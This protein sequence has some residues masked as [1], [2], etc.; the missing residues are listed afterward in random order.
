MR[1]TLEMYTASRMRNMVQLRKKNACF[2]TSL[3]FLKLLKSSFWALGVESPHGGAIQFRCIITSLFIDNPCRF[4][5]TKH[6]NMDIF[7]LRVATTQ[8][9]NQ[10]RSS[11]KVIKQ[12]HELVPA[13]AKSESTRISCVYVHFLQTFIRVGL[14]RRVAHVGWNQNV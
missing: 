6:R 7:F 5:K 1:K 13:G 3:P 11:A 9:F 2:V 4:F 8:M 10:P 12:G 14:S